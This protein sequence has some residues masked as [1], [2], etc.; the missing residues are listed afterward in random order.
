MLYL[1]D[2]DVS[3]LLILSVFQGR[4][5]PHPARSLPKPTPLPPHGRE[6][7][8]PDKVPGGQKAMVLQPLQGLRSKE[9]EEWMDRLRHL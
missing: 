5:H 9:H 8:V 2:L 6:R 3:F 4:H 7:T 1:T